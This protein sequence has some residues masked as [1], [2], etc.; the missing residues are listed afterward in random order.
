LE[1]VLEALREKLADAEKR[2]AVAEAIAAERERII[3][4]QALAL[5][6]LEAPKN[7]AG[8]K[9]TEELPSDAFSPASGKMSTVTS[10]EPASVQERASRP[11]TVQAPAREQ[12]TGR[13]NRFL[14]LLDRALR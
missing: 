4:V 13:P 8:K 12:P 7:L 5:R 11:P 3:E 6:M 14:R 2:A 1:P 9:T 10:E